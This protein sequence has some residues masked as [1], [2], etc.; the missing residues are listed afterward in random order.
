MRTVR[1]RFV[2]IF[3]LLTVAVLLT[4]FESDFLF[5]IQEQNLFLHTPLFF[6]QHMVTAGGLL[7]WI[8]CYFTQ[9]FY[10]PMLGVGILCLLWALLMWLLERAFRIPSAWCLMVLIPVAC[11]VLTIMELGYWIFYLKLSGYAFDA[12]IGSI[13]VIA[14]AWLYRV[15]PRRYGISTFYIVISTGIGY[16]LFGFYGLWAALLMAIM[17]WHNANC[18]IADVVVAIL[19]AIVIPLIYYQFVYHETNLV[20]IYWTALPVF[21]MHKVSYFSYYWPY[22][23]LIVCISLMAVGFPKKDWKWMQV[24]VLTITIGCVA[25]FWY[26]DANFH[27][28]LSMQRSMERQD[29]EQVLKTAR[30]SRGEPTR[31]MCMMQNLALYRLG[32]MDK[33]VFSY[34]NG[35]KRPDAPF[36]VRIV[37]TQGKQLYL[38]YGIPNYSHR[39]CMEDGVEYGWNVG[40]LQLMTK[41][42]LLNNEPIAAMRFA[43]LLNKTGFHK[44]LAKKYKAYIQNPALMMGDEELRPILPL[45]RQ[46]NFLTGDQ[47]QLEMFLVEHILS[48]PGTTREQQELASLTRYYYRNNRY[49]LIEQ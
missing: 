12:T 22:I 43:N 25:V 42:A 2:S 19:S 20:N 34:P 23:A 7:T 41:C 17:A 47:S 35:A 4:V 46:D 39:W 6:Q 26:K 45:L 1:K 16:P 38:Q 49:K 33:E 48:T 21:A 18:R 44:S 10:F 36:P 11:L 3:S 29:W 37:H 15:L 24:A 9:F 27:S 40:E 31:A 28:E 32:R 5:R 14:S 8:G 30:A 13:V